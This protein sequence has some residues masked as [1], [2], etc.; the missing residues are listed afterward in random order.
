MALL[1]QEWVVGY[2]VVTGVV[3]VSY[4]TYSVLLIRS[5]RKIGYDVGVSGMIP[6]WNI[7]TLIKRLYK[8]RK[9]KL[10]S[11]DEVFEI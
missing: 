11:S 3:I 4:I 10:V 5:C 1:A 8:G 9:N 6:I 2:S 7:V